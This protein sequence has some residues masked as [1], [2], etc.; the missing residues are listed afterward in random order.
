MY[1]MFI[2]SSSQLF[3]RI[4]H[5]YRV[6]SDEA[7]YARFHRFSFLSPEVLLNGQKWV[8]QMGLSHS[9]HFSEILVCDVFSWDFI[10]F[11]L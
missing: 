7:L 8:F 2:V 9:D 5:G 1:K 4:G 6:L 3:Q 11:K 10:V